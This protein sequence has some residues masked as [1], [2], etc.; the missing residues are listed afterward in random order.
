MAV[1]AKKYQ[2]RYEIHISPLPASEPVVNILKIFEQVG[3]IKLKSSLEKT[4]TYRLLS[5]QKL[6]T[7][8]ITYYEERAAREAI[9]RFNGT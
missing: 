4:Y 2:S 3:T 7:C 1:N 6:A 5:G 8:R 9:A